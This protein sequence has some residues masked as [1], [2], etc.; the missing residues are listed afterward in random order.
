MNA[1]SLAPLKRAGLVL[2]MGMGGFI[3]GILFHQILQVHAML[4]A[5]IP[6]TDLVGA[7]VN[8]FWDGIFHLAVWLM[9]AAG[10]AL[11]W[12]AGRQ[13]VRWCGVSFVGALLVGWGLFN[14]VEGVVDHH[15]LQLHHVYE[16]AGQ[17]VWDYAFLASGV[18]L[19]V[20]GIM[21]MRRFT[22]DSDRVREELPDIRSE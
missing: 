12:R 10:I 15:I 8:M 2:G 16:L 5:R 14:L 4:S 18:L 21:L 7:K 9:T 13:K 6:N 3:D 22:G 11:L 20:A 19:I 1:Q 17:S